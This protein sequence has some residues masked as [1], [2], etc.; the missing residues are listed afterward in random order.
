MINFKKANWNRFFTHGK[1]TTIRLKPLAVGLHK[2]MVGNRFK[3]ERKCVGMIE[4]NFVQAVKV[5]DLDG[6]NA[7]DDGFHNI[8]ELLIVL[9]H[10]NKDL[11]D[12]SNVY[13]HSVNVISGNNRVILKNMAR[14]CIQCDKQMRVGSN[15]HGA[16]TTA[17]KV[18]RYCKPTPKIVTDAEFNSAMK[19]AFKK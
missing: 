6:G 5:Y 7:N 4:V 1:K 2:A 11:T 8:V 14:R 15:S 19:I 3:G 12:S 17:R 16:T 18:C 13:I 10:L 9:A